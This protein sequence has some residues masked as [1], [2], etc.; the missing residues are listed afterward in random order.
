VLTRSGKRLPLRTQSSVKGVQPKSWSLG[1]RIRTRSGLLSGTAIFRLRTFERI[2]RFASTTTWNQRTPNEGH[3][4]SRASLST[5]RRS[6]C[7]DGRLIAYDLL[8]LNGEDLRKL[9]LHER[10]RQL[11][12][13]LS[14]NDVIRFSS[15]VEGTKGAALFRRACAMGLEGIVSKRIDVPYRS[16]PFLGWRKI[17]CPGYA[18]P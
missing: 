12:G 7:W 16:G 6:A 1:A 4:R 15:H 17:K 11:E 3:G 2:P 18:R 10:R 5:A 13:L 14:G 8:S 9:P